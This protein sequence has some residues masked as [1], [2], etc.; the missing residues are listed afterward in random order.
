MAT[1][2]ALECTT[3]NSPEPPRTLHRQTCPEMQPQRS[4]HAIKYTPWWLY[5]GCMPSSGRVNGHIPV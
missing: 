1:M 3:W 5:R 2:A 4:E